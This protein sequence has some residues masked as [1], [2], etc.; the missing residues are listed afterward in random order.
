MLKILNYSCTTVSVV[1]KFYKYKTDFVQ[2]WYFGKF[3]CCGDRTMYFIQYS[4]LTKG[5]KNKIHCIWNGDYKQLNS[6]NKEIN[7]T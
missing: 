5:Q 7:N 6:Q 4:N 1:N 3:C 2:Q